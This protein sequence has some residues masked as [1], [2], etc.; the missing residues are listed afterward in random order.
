MADPLHVICPHCETTNRVPSARLSD[1]PSCGRCRGKL[2]PGRPVVLTAGNFEKHI[3]RSDIP[4]LV[5]FWA[6]W[7]GPCKAMAPAF[8]QAAAELEPRVRLAKIDT[9]R[10]EALAARFQIRSIPTLVFFR[11]GRETARQSGALPLAAIKDWVSG[12]LT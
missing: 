11:G 5:D 9:E 1:R 2:F 8:E 7:C 12:Q 4:T 6:A 3:S 10:E